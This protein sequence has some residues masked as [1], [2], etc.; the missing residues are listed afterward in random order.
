MD[1]TIDAQTRLDDVSS[2][3]DS[4]AGDYDVMTDFDNRFV[5]E[6]PFF[7]ML[8]EKYRIKTALDAGS[9]TG[10]HSI[11]LSQLGVSVTAVDQSAQMLKV[12]RQHANDS[13]VD[14]QTV[15]SDFLLLPYRVA[16]SFDAVVC[17]GNALAH[18]LSSEDLRRVLDNFASVLAPR[19]ILF[20]QH[21]NYNRILHARDSIQ[22]VKEVGGTTFIRSYQYADDRL[23]FSIL[24]RQRE[25]GS[26]LESLRT[27]CLRPILWNELRLLLE[28]TGFSE[29]HA[30]G[31]IALDAYHPKT[32]HDL[33]VLARSSE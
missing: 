26:M 1:P 3:Y 15:E 10:F 16:R 24:K 6:R 20:L 27:I 21:L 28:E 9:G 32:S 14:V 29:I 7:R 13:G 19:G 5:K 11:L 8:V 2:F 23:H 33:V 4:L 30:Y 18:L 22:N 17:M 12:L 25:N 31:S